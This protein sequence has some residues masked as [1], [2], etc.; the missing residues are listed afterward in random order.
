MPL[1][2]NA[3]GPISDKPQIEHLDL[4]EV[5]DDQDALNIPERLVEL[6]TENLTSKNRV[7]TDDF[8]NLRVL[9]QGSFGK[10][11]LVKKVSGGDKNQL[12]AM[13]VLKKA[14]LKTRDRHRTKM[15]RDI[16]VSIDHPFIV[17][18]FYGFQTDAK[19]YLVL[20]FING[21]DLFTRL[22][23]EFI[24]KESLKVISPAVFIL[25]KTDF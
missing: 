11:F 15:E 17:K 22:S 21:G 10:V 5:A 20:E 12:Y 13:K 1:F 4:D 14:A 16:L 6:K 24:G 18:V 2:P 3:H 25:S 23:K 9:G 8:K 7:S 19:L